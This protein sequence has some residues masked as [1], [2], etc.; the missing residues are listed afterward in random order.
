MEYFRHADG[1]LKFWDASAGENFY[2]Y[3]RNSFP[4]LSDIMLWLNVKKYL[5]ADLLQKDHYDNCNLKIFTVP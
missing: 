4:N 1:S 3:L 2:L 5:L